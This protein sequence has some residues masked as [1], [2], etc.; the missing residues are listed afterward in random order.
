MTWIFLRLNYLRKL[1]LN[2]LGP[3][4]YGFITI[5]LILSLELRNF[6]SGYGIMMK[7]ANLFCKGFHKNLVPHLING[8]WPAK[9]EF[10]NPIFTALIV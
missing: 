1:P 10:F 7:V 9:K 3:V 6:T 4:I 5:D 8:D 2:L